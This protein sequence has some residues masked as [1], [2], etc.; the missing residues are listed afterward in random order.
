MLKNLKGTSYAGYR[1]NKLPIVNH[2]PRNT[3]RSLLLYILSIDFISHSHL[4]CNC[5]SFD[6]WNSRS[7]SRQQR[8]PIWF[9][10]V[11]SRSHFP[12][13]HELW[14][15]YSFGIYM[16]WKRTMYKQDVT[17]ISIKSFR[18]YVLLMLKYINLTFNSN[19]LFHTSQNC[20]I[21][22]HHFILIYKWMIISM[23][24]V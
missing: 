4:C 9:H 14:I 7:A 21:K 23:T 5:K 10:R 16:Y 3:Y 13:Q 19:N 24:V 22:Q 1:Y 18:D 12:S 6:N 2:F 17:Y 15:L 20:N 8:L 11:V